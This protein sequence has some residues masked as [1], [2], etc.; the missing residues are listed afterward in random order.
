[1]AFSNFPLKNIGIDPLKILNCPSKTTDINSRDA[2]YL[3]LVKCRAAAKSEFLKF[4]IDIDILGKLLT[5][6][7]FCFFCIKTKE[8]TAK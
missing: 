3:I 2:K 7:I 5:A 1:L 8:N 4:R 6:L